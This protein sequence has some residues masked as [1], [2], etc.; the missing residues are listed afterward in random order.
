MQNISFRQYAIFIFL[1]LF[2]VA[3][4]LNYVASNNVELFFEHETELAE[5]SINGTDSLIQQ[6]L[7]GLRKNVGHFSSNYQDKI[8]QLVDHPDN[9]K[10]QKSRKGFWRKNMLP[11]TMATC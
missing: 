1:P 2:A 4:L 3:A 5:T 11:I 6:Y 10:L 9:L 7:E 8:K